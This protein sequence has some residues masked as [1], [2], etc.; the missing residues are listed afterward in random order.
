[1][2][3]DKFPGSDQLQKQAEQKKQ[4]DYAREMNETI[5]AAMRKMEQANK[6]KQLADKLKEAKFMAQDGLIKAID[7]PDKRKQY[8]IPDHGW[9]VDKGKDTER[10]ID[11]S[12]NA[13]EGEPIIFNILEPLNKHAKAVEHQYQRLQE[14][15]RGDVTDLALTLSVVSH[16]GQAAIGSTSK[17]KDTYMLGGLDS[18]YQEQKGLKSAG[19]LPPDFPEVKKGQSNLYFAGRSYNEQGG[20]AALKLRDL[21]LEVENGRTLT[22]ACSALEI[23]LAKPEQ[24]AKW[25]D[26]YAHS[27]RNWKALLQFSGHEVFPAK[28]PE[29]RMVEAYGA[30][31]NQRYD[32]FVKSAMKD[33]ESG[34]KGFS[35][36]DI[37][38]LSTAA[39][40]TWT[41]TFFS[42]PGQGN[43]LLERFKNENRNLEDILKLQ[44]L[45]IVP[46][47]KMPHSVM[48]G[49]VNAAEAELLD[50]HLD[51][52]RRKK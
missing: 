38:R 44:E 10:K 7:I 30:V 36:D 18:F 9:L 20:K 3:G 28:I 41:V 16:E 25:N 15:K 19:Y 46:K 6:P 40:R 12:R 52:A 47:E 37:R 5:A 39:R 26:A 29:N 11:F 4:A 45:E 2:N 24:F 17:E 35:T 42:L 8:G 51:I 31:L 49:L 48:R 43:S 27:G 34:E 21:I 1:M 33:A 22:E 14:T 23:P 50:E 13:R 32:W